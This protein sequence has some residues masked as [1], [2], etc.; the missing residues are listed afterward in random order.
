MDNGWINGSAFLLWL[1]YFIHQVRPSPEKKV[2]LLMDNHIPH[3]YYLPLVFARPL[4]RAV[5]GP[6]KT[7]FEQEINTFQKAHPGRIVNQLDVTGLVT[8]VFIKFAPA[9]NAVH[10]FS[11]TG[12]WPFNRNI[13]GEDFAPATVA[14]HPSPLDKPVPNQD[15][16]ASPPDTPKQF[17]EDQEA[18]S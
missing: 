15:R 7:F 3:K 9:K 12:L 17:L 13:V 5:Y 10:G 1:Q 16:V 14:N 6:F 2:P 4:D 11:S 8:P 18:R